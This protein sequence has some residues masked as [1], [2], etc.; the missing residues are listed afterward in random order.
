MT[1]GGVFAISSSA[2]CF[3]VEIQEI[4]PWHGFNNIL[5]SVF[6]GIPLGTLAADFFTSFQLFFTLFCLQMDHE[7][8]WSCMVL[9]LTLLLFS[10]AASAASSLIEASTACE[11][12]DTTTYLLLRRSGKR[13]LF[14]YTVVVASSGESEG[15]KGA[16]LL[17][18]TILAAG[19]NT[20]G[21]AISCMAVMRVSDGLTGGV[22][23]SLS[24]LSVRFQVSPF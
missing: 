9:L 5:V 6:F 1:D 8:D 22:S 15:A 12:P 2:W 3:P 21:L 14:A 20:I 16:G 13:S 17:R 10:S 23:V 18:K 4:F 24:V 7:A 19:R 11:C